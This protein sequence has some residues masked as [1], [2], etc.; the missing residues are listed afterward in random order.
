MDD[1]F[2][3]DQ[4]TINRIIERIDSLRT[5]RGS[6]PGKQ[7]IDLIDSEEFYDIIIPNHTTFS[8]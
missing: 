7:Q 6:N 4:Q 1:I 5:E 2:F 3:D 8:F